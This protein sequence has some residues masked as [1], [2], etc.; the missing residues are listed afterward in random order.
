MICWLF[1]CFFEFVVVFRSEEQSKD[2]DYI[3]DWIE[4]FF[5]SF[6]PRHCS[7]HFAMAKAIDVITERE[8]KK[9]LKP[10][11]FFSPKDSMSWYRVESPLGA[12]LVGRSVRDS[13]NGFY[14]VFLRLFPQLLSSQQLLTCQ[15]KLLLFT[16]ITLALWGCARTHTRKDRPTG[17]T[18]TSRID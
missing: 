13:L 2:F 16:V 17:W 10:N 9:K 4:K 12:R 7:A 18:A 8:K 3:S 5:L 15:I 1:S 14:F 6:F 11:P